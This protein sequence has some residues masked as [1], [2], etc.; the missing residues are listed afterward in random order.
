MLN[1]NNSLK[2]DI[3]YSIKRVI[4]ADTDDFK[5]EVIEFLKNIPSIDSIDEDVVMN[6]SVLLD[7]EKILGLLSYEKFTT[8]GLIRY[9]IFKSIIS[10]EHIVE[11]FDDVIDSARLDNIQTL[12]SVINKEEVEKFF[13]ELGFNKVDKSK[14]V[15]DEENFLDTKYKDANIMLCRIW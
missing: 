2:G 4:E 3:M 10:N 5:K 11:L 14:F 15:I 6:A 8:Y 13:G 1:F 9:F 12:F 7:D